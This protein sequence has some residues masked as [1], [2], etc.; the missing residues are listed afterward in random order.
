VDELRRQRSREYWLEHQALL[1][2]T[3]KLIKE[4][5]PASGSR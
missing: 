1:A 5:R 3:D 2:E 4:Q